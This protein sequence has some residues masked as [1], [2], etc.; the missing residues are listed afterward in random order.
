M[1][2][3]LFPA[4]MIEHTAEVYL[5]K[6]SIKSQLIYTTVLLS[7]L[8]ALFALP[9]IFVDVSVQSDGIIR[10]INEKTEIKSLV[11]GTIKKVSVA[12]NQKLQE[13]DILFV[14]SAD[15][16]DI[17][18]NAIRFQDEEKQAFIND[19]QMLTH[20]NR[21]NLLQP[22]QTKTPVYTQQ[23]NTFRSILQENI[24]H[25]QKIRKELEADRFLYKEKVL[26]RR[27]L[28]AKE[29]ELTRLASEFTSV[30]ERQLSQWQ[31]DLNKQYF[32]L[33][34]LQSEATQFKQQKKYYE[35]KAP[36]NGNVQQIVGKYEGSYVQTGEVLGVISPDSSLLV[37][38]Y[39]NTQDIGLLKAGMPV[40]F[41]IDAFNY[42]EWG[43]IEGSITDIA[44]D[45]VIV[46]ERM[47]FKVRCRLNQTSLQLKNGYTA[48]LK[49]GLTLRARFM[50]AKRSLYQLLYDKADDWLNPKMVEKI[51]K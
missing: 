23:L 46:N 17:K 18:L 9:Y 34:Q 2:K 47:I 39:V 26:A 10:T 41:Q 4:Q 45:F 49:K 13:N 50:V 8:G 6:V 37:E 29:Y 15:D 43:M 16:L 24:A 30:V 38:C 1:Q 5:P 35:I 31:A 21:A 44:K 19:L 48:N 36:I 32:D 28:D 7:I 25:Q 14:V 22:I 51:D 27:E 42:N 20:I 33:K 3:Q 40:S 12:E 11:S